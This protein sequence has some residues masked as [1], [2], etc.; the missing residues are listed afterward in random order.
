MK[1][2]GPQVLLILCALFATT[3]L[4]MPTQPI[5]QVQA[6]AEKFVRT[7]LPPSDAKQFVTAAKMDSRL[8][9]ALCDQPLQAFEQNKTALGER[10]TVGV[11][12]ASANTWT[13]YVPVSVEV[14]IPVLV[15]RRALARRARVALVDVE[16]E[17][18]RMPGS[19]AVFIQD[20][21]SLQGHRLK[22]SLP[23][24]TA[25]TVDMLV[26]DLVVRRG[27]QV[28]L[29][30]ASG[31]FEIRAQ[32][33]ALTEGGVSDRVRVQNMSSLK[34]VEGVVESDSV[35]RVGL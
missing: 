19:A 25:L 35:V 24:G 30:A 4:A 14:E 20:A 10:V 27:Q 2:F 21:T 33:H 18:R 6:A 11:R 9:V 15:L 32:G 26:P 1:R 13:L 23:A 7:H 29:I 5:E 34:V 22:R 3:A 8:R 12:C 31:P 28:T 17:S 16:P